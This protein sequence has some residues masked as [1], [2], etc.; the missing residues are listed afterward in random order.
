[1]NYQEKYFELKGGMKVPPPVA[2]KKYKKVPPPVATKNAY[3]YLFEAIK[4][5]SKKSIVDYGKWPKLVKEKYER[6]EDEYTDLNGK[7]L[8]EYSS[9]S[10]DG[11]RKDPTE[12]IE[13]DVYFVK[14]V[15]SEIWDEEGMFTL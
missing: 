5:I 14:E 11:K 12:R 4:D 3:V 6:F 1:M 7:I 15:C 10:I 9:V 13:P 2:S 8:E